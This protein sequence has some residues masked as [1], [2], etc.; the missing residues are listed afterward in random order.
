M[1]NCECCP[2]DNLY[3]QDCANQVAWNFFVKLTHPS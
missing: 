3:A 1:K 2:V